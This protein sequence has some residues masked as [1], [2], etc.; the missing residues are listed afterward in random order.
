MSLAISIA[1]NGGFERLKLSRNCCV[2]VSWRVTV[3][4]LGRRG[5]DSLKNL[6]FMEIVDKRDIVGRKR[7][8][9]GVFF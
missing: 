7:S 9:S 4:C 3:E 8:W 1:Q 5:V 2:S 6:L